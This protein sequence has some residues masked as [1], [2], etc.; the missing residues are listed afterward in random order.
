MRLEEITAKALEMVNDDRYL[1]A[2]SVAKR[3]E[4]LSR[5]AMTK[6]PVDPKKIKPSDLALMEIAEGT[7]TVTSK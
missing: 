7:V 3:A 2:I 4:E 1:L 6:L 5:G